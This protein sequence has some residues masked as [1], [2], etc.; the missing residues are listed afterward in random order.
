MGWTCTEGANPI[1]NGTFGGNLVFLEN[2]VV[3]PLWPNPL[4]TTL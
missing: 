3:E 1:T 4:Q 2:P